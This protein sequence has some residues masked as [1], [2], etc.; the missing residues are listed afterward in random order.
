M[1]SVSTRGFSRE[2]FGVLEDSRGMNFKCLG[3]FRGK[4]PSVGDCVGKFRVLENTWGGWEF[5]VLGDFLGKNHGAPDRTNRRLIGDCS[6][7]RRAKVLFLSG[8]HYKSTW[9]RLT[10]VPF[11]FWSWWYGIQC[12]FGGAGCSVTPGIRG[13]MF[14]LMYVISYVGGANLLRHAEGATWLAIVTVRNFALFSFIRLLIRDVWNCCQV[15]ERPTF[16]RSNDITL[17][18]IISA[19][20]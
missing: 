4:I 9:S 17:E 14:I 13:A 2:K 10:C 5:R 18:G 20:S 15:W 16:V 19:L 7:Y 12:F 6:I 11:A 1:F 3:I 8:R